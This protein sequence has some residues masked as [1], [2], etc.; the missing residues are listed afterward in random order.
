MKGLEDT[1]GRRHNEVLNNL[2][3]D[4]L[5][6]GQLFPVLPEL[7]YQADPSLK[8]PALNGHTQIEDAVLQALTFRTM[9]IREAEIAHSHLRTFD[10]IFEDLGCH[11][12]PWANLR[13][14]L[15]TG[16]GCYWIEGKAGSGKSTL[17]K[18]ISTHPKTRKALKKWAGSSVTVDGIL[19][20]LACRNNITEESR[21]ASSFT[22]LH[23]AQ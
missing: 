4:Q 3:I 22:S 15:E 21:R 12:R 20:L 14:W 18:Y 16:T 8:F 9:F 1:V 7:L 23:T 2:F 6:S 10:W 17:M 19:F 13:N 11:Q 5:Q